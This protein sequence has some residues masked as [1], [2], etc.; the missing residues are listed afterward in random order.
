MVCHQVHD[1]SGHLGYIKTLEKVKERFYWPGYEN[2]VQEWLLGCDKCQRRNPPTPSPRAPLGTITA[3]FPFEK[4]SWDIMGPLPRSSKGNQY[5]LVITDI[6]SKWVE[7]YPL[8]S[9]NAETLASVLVNGFICRFGVPRSLH[10]D[11]GANF[12]GSVMKAICVLLGINRTQTSAYHPQGNGQVER[13]NRTLEAM[14][15]K[16]VADNQSDWDTHLPRVLFAYRTAIHEATRFSPFRIVY[17]RSPVLP[18]DVII[19]HEHSI[20]GQGKS[21]PAHVRD[22]GKSLH[23]MFRVIREHESQAHQRNKRRYDGRISGRSFVVGDRVW[24]YVPAVKRGTTKKFSCLWRGPY[25]VIDKVNMYNYKIQ[26]I[27][28]THTLVVHRNRMKQ[29]FGEPESSTVSDVRDHDEANGGWTR[30]ECMPD[31]AP[32]DANNIE[33]DR[34]SLEPATAHEDITLPT[35]PNQAVQQVPIRRSTRTRKQTDFGP[36]C[37]H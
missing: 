37:R 35:P 16:V 14:L 11:Q 2:D 4:V 28:S 19:G 24:L 32:V 21:I 5:I 36:F 3:T 33:E 15:S 20:Q 27:G 22:V 12:T 7:A 1:Q 9:T 18:V 23:S 31:I 13:F 6:F 30:M 25:T 29:C 8:P 17:G 26:L 10:S 34:N